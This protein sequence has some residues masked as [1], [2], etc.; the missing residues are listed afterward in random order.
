MR[1]VPFV[2]VEGPIGVGKT[3]LAAEISKQFHYHLVK[4]IV[5]ENPFLG[6]FYE[7]MEEWSFQTEMFFL[8]HRYKQ[9]E[10]IQ[11]RFLQQKVPV[12]AD[13]HMMKN[14]IFAKKTL[15]D[16]HYQKY[17]KIYNIL[18]DDLPQPN[19][20]IYL[21]ASLD[22]LLARIQ[23]RGRDFEKNIDPLYLQQLCA[24]YEEIFSLFEREHPHIPVLRFNGDELDF[25]QRKEDLHYILE[26]I[27]H[28]VKGVSS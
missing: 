21:H 19:I 28:V 22:T 2:A 17:A 11:H 6:K 5:E 18:T 15:K 10:E 4:E 14:L 3:S 24:D 16:H 1:V 12:V 27:N 23:Q 7:N 9:L 25:V 26:Q 20:I 8:C 13:Y